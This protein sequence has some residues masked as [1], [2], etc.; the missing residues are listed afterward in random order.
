MFKLEKYV[1]VT[2]L[3]CWFYPLTWIV[4]LVISY[5][6]RLICGVMVLIVPLLL[7]FMY[8]TTSATQAQQSDVKMAHWC[9][10]LPVLSVGPTVTIQV[11]DLTPVIPFLSLSLLV[12]SPQSSVIWHEMSCTQPAQQNLVGNSPELNEPHNIR[13]RLTSIE[14]L[15]VD[16]K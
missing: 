12:P 4:L 11:L 6:D 10:P 8:Y 2:E 1:V 5:I 14:K 13:C 7:M 16:L 9:E 15:C 3:C